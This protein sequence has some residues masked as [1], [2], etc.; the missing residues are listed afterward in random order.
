MVELTLACHPV[1]S[2]A[3]YLAVVALV[4]CA[5]FLFYGLHLYHLFAR[6]LW[7]SKVQQRMVSSI[8]TVTVFCT[9]CF[10]LRGVTNLV[11]TKTVSTLEPCN[12]VRARWRVTTCV[13]C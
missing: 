3:S 12:M 10:L 7:K 6:Q 4:S 13:A 9:L 1:P 8:F 2:C 5:A 11:W